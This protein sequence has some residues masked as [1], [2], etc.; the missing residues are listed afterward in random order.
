MTVRAASMSRCGTARMRRGLVIKLLASIAVAALL[1]LLAPGAGW[2]TTVVVTP[3]PG[4]PLQDAIDAAAPGSKVLL[5]CGTFAE[6]IVVN[7]ALT[8]MP[9]PERGCSYLSIDAS[10]TNAPYAI[11]IVADDVELKGQPS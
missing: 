3:G 10:S 1:P 11:D 9:A 7:K 5:E 6:A 2:C 8:L 4:T